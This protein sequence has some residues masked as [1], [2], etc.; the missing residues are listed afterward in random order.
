MASPSMSKVKFGGNTRLLTS[1]PIHIDARVL[2]LYVYHGQATSRLHSDLETTRTVLTAYKTSALG[3]RS[4]SGHLGQ[5]SWFQIAL[6]EA[7]WT[8][9]ASTQ[10][11]PILHEFEAQRR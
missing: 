7:H 2:G 5:Y 6:D 4:S 11:L 10:V 8:H 1:P 3:Q 9:N